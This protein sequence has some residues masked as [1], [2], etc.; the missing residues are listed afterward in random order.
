MAMTNKDTKVVTEVNGTQLVLDLA[1]FPHGALVDR[2]KDAEYDIEFY[3]VPESM[4]VP[5]YDPETCSTVWMP[6]KCWSVHRGKKLEIVTLSDGSQIFT[7]DDPRAV[8]GVASDADTLVPQRFRPDEALRRGVLVPVAT[9]SLAVDQTRTAW[10]DFDTG[11]VS[12]ERGGRSV[13]VDFS[14]GQFVG[15]MAGDG[16]ADCHNATHLSDNEGFNA[17]F[18]SSFLSTVYPGFYTHETV[19]AASQY[20]GRYGDTRRYSMRTGSTA[21]GS[22]IKELV[23]GHGDD[24]TSGSANKRLPIWYQFAGREFILGLV[25]GLIATDGSVSISRAKKS[26]QLQIQFSSTSL[27][28]VREF[29]RCC[30]LLGCRS[31]VQFSKDTSGGNVSWV[32]NVSSV[33]AKRVGLLDRCCNTRKRD[34]FTSTAV[35]TDS[36][37]VRNELLPLPRRLSR[38]L[39]RLVP[40]IKHPVTQE[41][42]D[43]YATCINLRR[44]AS[45]GRITRQLVDKITELGARIAS[46]NE[47]DA[48]AGREALDAIREDLEAAIPLARSRRDARVAVSAERLSA[49]R[50][51][52]SA[53]VWKDDSV[54]SPSRYFSIVA[55]AG[56]R[57]FMTPAMA[58]DLAGFFDRV[59][60]NTALQDS[61]ELAQLQALSGSDVRWEPVSCVEK[62]GTETVGYDLTVPGYDTF[63]NADGVVLSNTMNFHVPSSDRAVKEAVE[64]MLPSKNLFSTTDLRSPNYAPRME[65]T[66]GLA[67][68]TAPESA[69]K[70]RVFATSRDAIRAY[71][72]GEIGA[73]DPVS[74]LRT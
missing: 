15:V 38:E 69:A 9:S 27:R 21:L 73:N 64:K 32:C 74:V 6:V 14:F 24:I 10:Y 13:P 70:P 59:P 72:R 19:Y 35:S 53:R 29:Q 54:E 48:A 44:R 50:R 58:D 12:A 17:S 23:D 20:T 28:L 7:D 34:V 60:V 25:N 30:R 1:D 71:R 4:R 33:D 68:L 45:E 47:A 5:S 8:Y 43:Q 56:C 46:A 36:S 65:M 57:G 52:V 42:K 11:I 22:R 55:R 31:R 49:L 37:V 39:V 41:E 26:E 63:V 18:V 2:R 61:T 62:T 51:G 66:L 40:S 16:W 3:S 67:K